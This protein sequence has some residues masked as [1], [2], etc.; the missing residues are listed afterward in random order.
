MTQGMA[1]PV[2]V[3]CHDIWYNDTL[4]QLTDNTMA[5]DLLSYLKATAAKTN[6]HMLMVIWKNVLVTS[7]LQ[8]LHEN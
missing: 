4:V 3:I 1:I 7:L 5:E 6:I 2:S 8:L